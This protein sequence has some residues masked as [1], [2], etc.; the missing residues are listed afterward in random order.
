MV[1]KKRLNPN[2]KLIFP[3]QALMQI[4]QLRVENEASNG[5]P[6]L[7]AL[8]RTTELRSLSIATLKTIQ[9]QLRFD[10]E[11]VEKVKQSSHSGLNSWYI[12]RYSNY[13]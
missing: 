6:Y 12:Q 1:K 8:R 5:G 4:T 7:H 2:P 11:E 13:F 9:S 3:V 10:L